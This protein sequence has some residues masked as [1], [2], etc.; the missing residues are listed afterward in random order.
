MLPLRASL[1]DNAA[2]RLI[3]ISTRMLPFAQA[4]I[5]QPRLRVEQLPRPALEQRLEAALAERALILFSAPAG[6][7][8]TVLLSRVLGEPRPDRAIAWI[9]ADE[10]DDLQRL[11]LALVAALEPHDLPWRVAPETLGNLTQKDQPRPLDAFID[12]LA[13]AEVQRGVI[14]IEDLHRLRD[15]AIFEWLDRLIENLPPSW[16][17]AL[18]SRVDPP[19]ALA[20]WRARGELAEFRAEDLRFTRDESLAL[21]R[22]AG[23]ESAELVDALWQ[24]TH[25]WPVGLYLALN[26]GNATQAGWT[27][28]RH[29]FDYLTSEVLAQMPPPLR[30]FLLRCSLLPE[31]T[32]AR[33]AAVSADPQAGLRLD[34]IERRGLFVTQ[35][36]SHERTLRLHD[37][38][39]D[40]LEEQLQQSHGSELPE[41]LR[42]AAAAESDPARRIG[43]L[44]RSGDPEAAQQILFEMTPGLLLDGASAQVL[45]LLSLFPSGLRETSPT[46]AFVRGLHA[47][48]NFDWLTLHQTMRLAGAGFDREGKPQQ[49]QE[50]RLFEALAL[51][52]RGM[53][54]E[55][56][57]LLK[58]LR[59]QDLPH[60]IA[61]FGE[62]VACWHTAACGPLEAPAQH[63]EKMIDLLVR[64]DSVAL[65]HRCN[66]HFVFL[67]HPG[68]TTQ[69]A[70]YVELAAT[71]AGDS[72]P[73]MSAG[74]NALKAWLKLWDGQLDA[75]ELL[76]REVEEDE[77]WLGHPNNLRLQ[78]SVLR[79]L[80]HAVR[81]EKAACLAAK[82]RAVSVDE[83]IERR[84]AW[85]SVNLYHLSRWYLALD[86]WDALEG[87]VHELNATPV[88]QEWPFMQMCRPGL[89]ALWALHRDEP[90]RVCELLEPV[91]PLSAR[92][93]MSAASTL[94][95]VTLALAY[96]RLGRLQE[97]WATLAP[98]LALARMPGERLTL[99]L[100]GTRLLSELARQPWQE[101]VPDTEQAWL[102]EM[103]D[104]SASLRADHP[105]TATTGP[106]QIHG[107]SIR[108]QEVLE[109]IAAG[110]SNKLIARALDL[111]PHTVKRHVA[112]ILN[113]LDLATPGQA[114]AWWHARQEN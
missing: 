92:Y 81:G 40:F 2:S 111:S 9:S 97:A 14:V 99:L 69:L 89:N 105:E 84:N 48:P 31:L 53:L 39:R 34:E 33:C 18:S 112:N 32:A 79:G 108:E 70:R 114:A 29:A 98:A 11:M 36:Q 52:N 80:L 21:A 44:L 27:A 109:R 58:A 16:C 1:P 49:A 12:A 82:A 93:D 77:R 71:M 86:D 104:L 75:A 72:H 64:S 30:Q 65:W 50:A 46:L 26:T 63:L 55:A 91:L 51:L 56:G 19:L 54:E 60:G 20:R 67:G 4:K 57:N 73:F 43:Y 85:R 62:L 47:W 66:P 113:K 76:I 101:N 95:R 106:L 96:A 90:Q 3:A 100:V 6:Y 23:Q 28:D 110:D 38:F 88:I 35:L 5:Q 7:G 24:R 41:L 102:R 22:E 45:H 103:A 42:R 94:I 8:K 78:I 83:D 37:L 107:L 61:A 17:L 25:G 10:D 13:G 68:V 59:A 15:G 74:I 87:T